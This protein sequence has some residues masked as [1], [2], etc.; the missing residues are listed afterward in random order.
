MKKMKKI[1]KLLGAVLAV[2]AV[3]VLLGFVSGKRSAAPCESVEVVLSGYPAAVLLNEDDIRIEIQRLMET[4]VGLPMRNINVGELESLIKD[5]PHVRDVSVYKTIDKRLVVE[6]TERKPI[7]RLI[8]KSGRSALLDSQGHL[9]PLPRH[10]P[11][12]LPVTTGEF[13]ISAEDI[14]QRILI[15]DST[16]SPALQEIQ[17][18]VSTV[19]ADEFWSAQLQQT[20]L[21]KHG[22]FHAIPRVGNHEIIFGPAT[23]LKS[24][25]NTLRIFYREGMNGATWNKYSKI[26]LKYKDQI[27]CTKK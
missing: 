3:F 1:F 12:R 14:S 5:I 8:D 21:D 15:T 22:D 24:K 11:I 20:Y 17:K 18:F 27:V 2:A 4:P 9:I 10:E 6:V 26:N 19:V 25:L 23:D 13:E 7:A 16:A